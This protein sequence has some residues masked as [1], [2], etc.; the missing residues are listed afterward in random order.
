MADRINF[1]FKN[2]QEKSI[3]QRYHNLGMD[4]ICQLVAWNDY[5]GGKIRKRENKQLSVQVRF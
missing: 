1:I 3:L 4:A 5:D 2:M